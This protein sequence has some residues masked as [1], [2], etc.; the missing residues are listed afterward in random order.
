MSSETIAF[1]SLV[2]MLVLIYAGLHVA[3]TLGLLSFVG[4][5]L[6]RG[7]MDIAAK[8]ALAATVAM[9]RPPRMRRNAWLATSKASLPTSA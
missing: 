5:W 8:T 4:V 1:G 3:I 9:P 7:D 6:I 2:L